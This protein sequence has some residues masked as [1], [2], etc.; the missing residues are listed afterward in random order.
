MEKA[1]ETNA[2]RLAL[3]LELELLDGVIEAL[4]HLR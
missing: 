1:A 3:V 2:S 4:F